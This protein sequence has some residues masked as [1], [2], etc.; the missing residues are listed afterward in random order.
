METSHELF[1]FKLDFQVVNFMVYTPPKF[2]S[3]PEK[4]WW[5]EDKSLSYWETFQAFPL[6]VK[7][8]GCSFPGN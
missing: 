2:N 8:H 4:K 7:L 6:A 1:G 5:L 3:S